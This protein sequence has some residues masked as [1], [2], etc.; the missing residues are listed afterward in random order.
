MER[1]FHRT[2]Y[3]NGELTVRITDAAH[4]IDTLNWVTK[5]GLNVEF[6]SGFI[7]LLRMAMGRAVPRNECVYEGYVT[8]AVPGRDCKLTISPDS[9]KE[10]SFV[11]SEEKGM[12]GGFIYHTHSKTWGIHT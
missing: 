11:W 4:F 6:A 12:N 3:Q 1:V 10:P 7:W 5:E 2:D 8:E 9:Y